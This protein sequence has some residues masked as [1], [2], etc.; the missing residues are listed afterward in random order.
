[1]SATLNRPEDF[2][3]FE[4]KANP[5]QFGPE[6]TSLMSQPVTPQHVLALYQ[7]MYNKNKQTGHLED[8]ISLDDFTQD[9]MRMALQICHE[10]NQAEKRLGVTIIDNVWNVEMPRPLAAMYRAAMLS[11]ALRGARYAAKQSVVSKV[12]DKL[13]KW[14]A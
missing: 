14:F 6:F 10:L 2:D 13:R 8:M 1:M 5:D 11:V 9:D 12:G 4:D 3:S 7:A